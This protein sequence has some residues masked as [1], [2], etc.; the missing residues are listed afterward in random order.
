MRC[1][2]R[3]KAWTV[4]LADMDIL[5]YVRAVLHTTRFSLCTP[6]TERNTSQTSPREA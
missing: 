5:I 3:Q 2:S 1:Q 4:Q 6:K